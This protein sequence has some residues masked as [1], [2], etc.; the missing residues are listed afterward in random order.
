MK[1]RFLG[2]IFLLFLVGFGCTSKQ[3]ST[4]APIEQLPATDVEKALESGWQRYTD[5]HGFQLDYPEDSPV[6][7]VFTGVS[8]PQAVGE[9]ERSLKIDVMVKGN[10]KVDSDGCMVWK[11][12]HISKE[13]IQIGSIPV[14]LT[15]VNEGAAG[16]TYSTYHYTASLKNNAVVDIAMTIRYPTSVRVYA[17]CENDA[18]QAKQTCSE[19]AFDKMRETALFNQIVETLKEL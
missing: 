16:S 7:L 19:L 1:I 8:L 3:T 4:P 5:A 18:D 12:S 2:I 14:C 9:K 15:I 10:T 11:T 6:D 13:K 17:G